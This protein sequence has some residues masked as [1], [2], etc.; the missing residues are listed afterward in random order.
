MIADEGEWKKT[1]NN[2]GWYPPSSGRIPLGY[3][4]TPSDLKEGF[5]QEF[6][7]RPTGYIPLTI[8]YAEWRKYVET[9]S[10]HIDYRHIIKVESKKPKPPERL[11][12]VVGNRQRTRSYGET[13]KS[14][15][16]TGIGHLSFIGWVKTTKNFFCT[17][18]LSH[19]VAPTTALPV[20]PK[21]GIPKDDATSIRLLWGVG[22]SLGLILVIALFLPSRVLGS[23]MS[24]MVNRLPAPVMTV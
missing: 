1:V 10:H 12:K 9:I 8:A 23:R 21:I 6:R 16:K 22:G 17:I 18:M 15:S 14:D 13:L 24:N 19:M 20:E 5:D 4:F 7:T 11:Q 2:V 3:R